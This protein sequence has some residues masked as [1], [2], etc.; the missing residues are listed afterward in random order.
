MLTLNI[1]F[2]YKIEYVYDKIIPISAI[3]DLMFYNLIHEIK[4]FRMGGGNNLWWYDY[5]SNRRK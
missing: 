5:W 2:N 1:N 3:N 4:M